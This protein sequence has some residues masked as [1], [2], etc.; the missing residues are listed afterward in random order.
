MGGT[1]DN[2]EDVDPDVLYGKG[3]AISV[4]SQRLSISLLFHVR[5]RVQDL[6][7]SVTSSSGAIYG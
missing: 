3:G 7:D 4:G 5:S 1:V 2:W 6:M